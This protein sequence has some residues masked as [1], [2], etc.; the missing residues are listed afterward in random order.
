MDIETVALN[1]TASLREFEVDDTNNGR[2]AVHHQPRKG[3]PLLYTQT[4]IISAVW[5]REC[6]IWCLLNFAAVTM[7]SRLRDFRMYNHLL[8]NNTYFEVI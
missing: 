5:R 2:W 7:A 8:D 6:L 1:T 4:I 3:V